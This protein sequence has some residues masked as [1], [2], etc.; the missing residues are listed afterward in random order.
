MIVPQFCA[1]S[2]LRHLEQGK[3]LTVRRFGGSD[4]SQDDAQ[5]NPDA[6]VKEAFERVLAGENCRA[7][8]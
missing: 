1:E 4:A 6:P 8:T 2:E 5:A 7:G 3:Q